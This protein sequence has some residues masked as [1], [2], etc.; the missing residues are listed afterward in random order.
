[1]WIPFFLA[2]A[3]GEDRKEGLGKH[4]QGDMSIPGVVETDLVVVESDLSFSGLETFLDGPAC[5][6]DA[7]EF[8][9]GF[10][11]WVV[12]VIEGEFALVDGPT[13]HVLVIGFVGVDDRPVV[14]AVAFRADSAGAP[15][16]R[17]GR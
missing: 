10:S 16:P 8:P 4:G 5:T 3:V 17:V 1:V 2:M 12:A 6:G 13:N 7:D 15:G 11:A 14:D 9:G